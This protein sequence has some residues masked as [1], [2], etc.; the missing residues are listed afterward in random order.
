MNL[1]IKKDPESG[2]YYIDLYDL[3]DYFHDIS[4]I[5]Y[6]EL[7]ELEDGNIALRFFDKNNN[8]VSPKEL[9]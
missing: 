1:H 8:V 6:Y 7:E 3:Q 5:E 4:I 2:E 9:S